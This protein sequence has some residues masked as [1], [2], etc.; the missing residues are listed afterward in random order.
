MYGTLEGWRAYAL[1]RG[2][3]SPTDA[4]DSDANAALQRASD[5]IRTRY[6][7]RHGLNTDSEEVQEA[8]YIAGSLELE[9]PGFW[10]KTFKPAQMKT[11]TKADVVSWTPIQ[12]DGYQGADL[13]Q[14][15]SPIIEAL[16]APQEGVYRPGIMSV[17]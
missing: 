2:D 13:M 12:Q 4:D 14:P 7:L 6:V 10:S 1:E 15:V 11:L 5:Y 17:G 16:L 9:T 8:T 3:S